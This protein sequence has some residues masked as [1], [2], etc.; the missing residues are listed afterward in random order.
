[1]T[2]KGWTETVRDESL[3]GTPVI[4]KQNVVEITLDANTYVETIGDKICLI[5]EVHENV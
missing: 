3:D 4:W 1:M 5:E 2:I